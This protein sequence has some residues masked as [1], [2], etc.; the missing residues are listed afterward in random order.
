MKDIVPYFFV[1][2]RLNVESGNT[3]SLCVSNDKAKGSLQDYE[4]LIT[5]ITS[6]NRQKIID[7]L[8]FAI[9]NDIFLS[10]R[11]KDKARPLYMVM[12]DIDTLAKYWD[13]QCAKCKLKIL[14][15]NH[16]NIL[17]HMTHITYKI[18]DL[19]K[20]LQATNK[21]GIWFAISDISILH[22]VAEKFTLNAL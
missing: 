18:F 2:D 11:Q 17:T 10:N 22:S 8:I 5:P 13:I 16:F 4:N 12:K 21:I 6:K 7:T 20:T 14:I 1:N 3:E 19:G 15:W 9:N